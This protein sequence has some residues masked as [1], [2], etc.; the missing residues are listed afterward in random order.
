MFLALI[1]PFIFFFWRSLLKSAVYWFADIYSKDLKQ[2]TLTNLEQ[3]SPVTKELIRAGFKLAEKMPAKGDVSFKY[4]GIWHEGEKDDWEYRVRVRRCIWAIATFIQA[5][6]AYYWRVQ[7][8]FNCIKERTVKGLLNAFNLVLQR[9]KQISGKVKQLYTLL[10][11]VLLF[12]RK[13]KFVI[14][15]LRELDFTKFE[16]DEADRYFA[17]RRSCYDFDGKEWNERMAWV[18][19]IDKRDGNVIIGS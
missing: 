15:Y 3:F 7:D 4:E 1:S 6:S 8:G 17:Y 11:L 2:K 5:D 18:K 19:E 16:P 13:R 12:Q 9:E 10:R 14:M